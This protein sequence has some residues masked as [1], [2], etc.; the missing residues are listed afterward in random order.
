ME[1]IVLNENDEIVMKLLYYFITKEGYSPIVLHGA[2]DEIWLE[3]L[4]GNYKI[5]RIVSNYIHND[6]Q[7]D[8]DLFK[9]KQII[10]KIKKKTFSFNINTLSLF[11]NLGDNVHMDGR[12][13]N[14]VD[15]ANIKKMN[16]L[17][18]YQFIIDEFP[19]ITKEMT[20]KEKGMELFLK[21][22]KDITNKN[23]QEA[24]KAEDVFTKRKPYI[25]FILIAINAII[26]VLSNINV[27]I[28]N[29]LFL[30]PNIEGE[31]YRLIT[32]VFTHYNAFH[33]L[34]NMYALY[35]VGPQIENF[36]GC[37][38]YLIIYLGSGIIASLMS[39]TLLNGVGSLGASGAIFGLFGSLLYFGYHYRLYLGSILKSQLIPLIFFNLMIGFIIPGIDN[40]AHIGGL[41]G[42]ITLSMAI[43]V[44]YKSSNID[45]VNGII[46][47][48]I[49][50]AFLIYT[51]FYTI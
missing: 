36:F 23:E 17:K 24:K 25:T 42:G 27:D 43:G 45:M 30:A 11:L 26:F 29:K 44:K 37:I 3:K 31:Y 21:I 47:S 28:L 22:T 16:D 19:T 20:M 18:K 48:V 40:A 2:K 6:E 51:A 7:L 10:K 12:E 4:D 13:Y 32:S 8:F 50:V 9:T 34:F 49:L 15:C 14:N 5:V 38:K 41:V 39:L 1:Q 46:L 35:I 33:F